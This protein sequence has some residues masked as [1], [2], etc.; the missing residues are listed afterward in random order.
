[1]SEIIIKPKKRVVTSTTINN[2]NTTYN[3][4][5]ENTFLSVLNYSFQT[6]LRTSS[7]SNEKLKI[8]HWKIA[9]DLS[10]QLKKVSS[11]YEVKALWFEDWKEVK[12]K[13]AFLDKNV[14]ITILKNGEVVCWIAVKFVMQ[15]YL[16]NS[17]NYF[18][19]MIW[20][21][22]NIKG[23]NIPYH[24][25]LIIPSSVPYYYWNWKI[26]KYEHISDKN[27]TKYLSLMRQ[28]TK[29]THV[30]SSMLLYIADIEENLNLK[31]KQE[32]IN[33]FTWKNNCLKKSI[34]EINNIWTNFYYNQYY[35]FIFNLLYN[36]VKKWKSC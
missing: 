17:N 7:T 9:S 13:W 24:Q 35:N 30:P 34:Y 3:N 6:F 21:T 18:E 20:E 33:Y 36:L 16:Q 19:N 22:V 11:E 31:T 23:K 26:K 5:V 29:L 1:M 12:V 4:T 28:N 32:Y 2:I 14:D 25:I 8:L 27:L 10:N 15:N